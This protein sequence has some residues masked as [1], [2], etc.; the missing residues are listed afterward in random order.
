MS[1]LYAYR[2]NVCYIVIDSTTKHIHVHCTHDL[3]VH[4][5]L[6]PLD[7]DVLY[8]TSN[9]MYSVYTHIL[10]TGGGDLTCRNAAAEDRR[11][12]SGSWTPRVA[13]RAPCLVGSL[14]KCTLHVSVTTMCTHI[15]V[16]AQYQCTSSHAC[17]TLHVQ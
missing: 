6:P 12:S 3:D 5:S 8:S 2:V 15:Y 17:V 7:S 11:S 16:L 4:C 1:L 10:H 14:K 9:Y 13:R